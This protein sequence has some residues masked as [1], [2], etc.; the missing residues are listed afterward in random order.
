LKRTLRGT[1]ILFCGHGLK[2]QLIFKYLVIFFQ[3]NTLKG[4]AKAPAVDLL[5]LKTLRGTKT[6]FLSPKGYDEH[7]RPFYMG[8]PQEG[9]RGTKS[10]AYSKNKAIYLKTL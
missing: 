2:N 1:K 8:F 5:R 6:A 10:P 7:P 3:L 4:T 9:G